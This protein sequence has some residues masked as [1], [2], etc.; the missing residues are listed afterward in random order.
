MLFWI[1]YPVT[2]RIRSNKH[3]FSV[4]DIRKELLW[5]T[6]FHFRVVWRLDS[7]TS[8]HD[9]PAQ[10]VGDFHGSE[11]IFFPHTEMASFFRSTNLDKSTLIPAILR[12]R[13]ST[14]RYW[15]EKCFALSTETL[16]DRASEL[17]HL[18]FCYGGVNRPSPFLCLLTKMMQLEPDSETLMSFIEYSEGSPAND[19]EMRKIDLRYLRALTVVY[20][21][22]VCKS[23]AIFSLLEKLLP[24]YRTLFAVD[25]SGAFIRLSVDELIEMLLDPENRPVFGFIF[26]HLVKREVLQRRGEV[27]MYASELDSELSSAFN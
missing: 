12:D 10:S 21:R 4:L 1:V 5:R 23:S 20:I 16:I 25:P 2:L 24:D 15:R 7:E 18:G 11:L 17:N 27:D 14:S 22:L 13:V 6:Y 19:L 8:V 26:P 9:R 3:S